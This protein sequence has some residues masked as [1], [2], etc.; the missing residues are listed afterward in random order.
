MTTDYLNVAPPQEAIFTITAAD[1]VACCGAAATGFIALF[2]LPANCVMIG[3]RIKG[4]TQF[5]WG[6]GG[7]GTLKVQLGFTDSTGVARTFGSQ[8]AD[9]VATAV[10][11]I[12]PL[13]EGAL[14]AALQLSAAVAGNLLVPAYGGQTSVST[15]PTSIGINVASSVSNINVLATGAVY[16]FVAYQS[17]STT[18]PVVAFNPNA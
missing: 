8:S 13:T 9:L 5:T 6:A 3:Y 2:N 17:S 15:T 14:F 16:I 11:D 4:A 7:S 1:M 18:F 10:T 12:A